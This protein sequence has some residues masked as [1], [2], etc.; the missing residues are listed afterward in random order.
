[1]KRIGLLV[2]LSK[3]H[4]IDRGQR[5]VA[6]LEARGYQPH[7]QPLEA[8]GLGRPDLALPDG[9]PLGE[10]DL[11]IVLGGDGTLLGA[12]KLVAEQ[13]TPILGINTGHLG[14]L[15][16]FD[17][18]EDLDHLEPIL[19]GSYQLER[20]MMLEATVERAGTVVHRQL[21]LNEAVV[22][23]GA[24]PQ[25]LHLVI[26]VGGHQVA[27]YP[28]DG[29]IIATPT[30][31]TAYSLSAGGPILSPELELL[32]LTPICSHTLGARSL[33]VGGDQVVAVTASTRGEAL[34]TVDGV[35]P[36][37]LQEGD[38]VLVQRS[39]QTANLVRRG[40]YRFPELVRQKFNHRT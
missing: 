7:L 27:Q 8:E 4:A 13:G 36:F 26:A 20:R 37:P 11:L 34:L 10:A 35:N 6:W 22:S 3:P 23:R 19:A 18:S 5:L 39:E 1:M 29:L 17:D 31:S 25:V 38:R 21:G 15:T 16:E 33:V 32:L 12:A 9:L 14:F 28:A 40:S 24:L 30:G 2:N